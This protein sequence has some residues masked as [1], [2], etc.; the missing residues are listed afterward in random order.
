MRKG[1]FIIIMGVMC[2]LSCTRP[3][4]TPANEITNVLDSVYSADPDYYLDV[5]SGTDEV[6]ECEELVTLPGLTHAQASVAIDALNKRI[7]QDNNN[8]K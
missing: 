5:L 8:N 1:L 2:L 3:T 6:L 4:P 7:S